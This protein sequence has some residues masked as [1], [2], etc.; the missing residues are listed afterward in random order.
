MAQQLPIMESFLTIQGEGF[1]SGKPAYFI[2]TG[3][4]DVGCVWCDV[5]ESWDAEKH[6]LKDVQV[7]QE[8]AL[9]NHSDWVVLTGGE[10]AMYDLGPLVQ[11]LQRSCSCMDTVNVVS[12]RLISTHVV[13]VKQL[14]K[15]IKTKLINSK[16]Q[17]ICLPYYRRARV[18]QIKK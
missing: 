13:R 8:E 17:D 11:K 1:H 5:K 4:C 14:I 9:V 15:T 7:L 6:P 3:G 16:K 10:P 12:A 18:T 2:R